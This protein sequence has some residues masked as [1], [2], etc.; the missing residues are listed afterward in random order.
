[1]F[2]WSPFVK[3]LSELCRHRQQGTA[4]PAEALEVLY[5]LWTGLRSL[6]NGKQPIGDDLATIEEAEILIRAYQ[7]DAIGA[8]G[9]KFLDTILP[10]LIK[11]LME[12]LLKK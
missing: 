9:G 6:Q 4:T 2:D 11:M 5:L 10:I 12:M 1:M 8:F 3:A 7:G